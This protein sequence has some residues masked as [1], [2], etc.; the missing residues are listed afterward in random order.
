M[1]GRARGSPVVILGGG[2][3][4]LVAAAHLS[5]VQ[6]RPV[7]VL[8][9]SGAPGGAAG[10][11]R[12]PDGERY[13]VTYHHVMEGDAPLLRLLSDLGIPYSLRRVQVGALRSGRFKPITGAAG[14]L[15][16]GALPLRARLGLAA[17]GAVTLLV[18]DPSALNG[19]TCRE[20][21]GRFLGEQGFEE[22]IAPFLHAKFRGHAESISAE[23][24]VRRV[25]LRE[26]RGQFGLPQGGFDAVISALVSSATRKGAALHL[27]TEATEVRIRH[28]R[29]E[30]VRFRRGGDGAMEQ[31]RPAAV[32][33]TLPAPVMLRL[34][35]GAP[36]SLTA[37]LRSCRYIACVNGVLGFRHRLGNQ[38][39][40][41]LAGNGQLSVAAFD[42][43]ALL[44]PAPG[45]GSV[46]YLAAY[47]TEEEQTWRT[48]DD[49]LLEGFMADAER[50][51]PGC[52]SSLCWSRVTRIRHG[53]PVYYA[54]YRK[55]C[56]TVAT[57]VEGLFM[58]GM[59]L[60][61]PLRNVGETAA[62]ARRAAKEL[63][64]TLARR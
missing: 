12:A 54:G 3:S 21:F 60:Y 45:R 35:R 39:S 47:S 58:A 61:P 24:L 59:S 40:T 9:R 17:A 53:K 19:V 64:S 43:A 22:S 38:Y 1:I 41:V 16:D 33:S 25:R 44:P 15:R 8:E 37:A 63:A 26:D 42:H 20:W 56:P 5:A 7:I 55:H 2:I 34:F 14:L 29:V 46:L 11:F 23:W 52:G 13:P 49:H 27:G 6:P 28:G 36:P 57:P 18:R 10:S 62:L 51:Y 48:G 50:V 30:E 31:L 32:L 4:G